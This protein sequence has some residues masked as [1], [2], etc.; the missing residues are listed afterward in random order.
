MSVSLARTL[1]LCNFCSPF[2][3]DLISPPFCYLSF[4]FFSLLMLSM[5]RARALA[6]ECIERAPKQRDPTHGDHGQ[7]LQTDAPTALIISSGCMSS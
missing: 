3:V 5:T 1:P 2:I 7:R 6:I 4:N